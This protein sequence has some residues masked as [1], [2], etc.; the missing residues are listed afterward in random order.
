MTNSAALGLPYMAPSQ[1][2]KHVTH[3]EALRLLDLIVQ[4]SVVDRTRNTPPTGA[5][6]G[7]R[8][9]V[10]PAPTGIW[11]GQSAS[12]AVFESGN[13]SFLA[14]GTGWQAYIEDEAAMSVW[15]GSAWAALGP[16]YD[17]LPGIGINAT[18]DATNRL[19]LSAAATLFNHE[20][21]GHQLKINK[22]AAADTASLL[23][24]TNWSGRA[25]MGTAGTDGFAIKV[26]ADGSA[27]QDAMVFDAATGLATGAAV[28]TAATDTGAGKLMRADFGYG[29]GNLLGTVAQGAGTPTG[30]VLEAGTEYLRLA[31]GTQ[32]A[33]T[34]LG[35]ARIDGATLGATWTLPVPFAGDAFA[36]G[37]FD[38]VSASGLTPGLDALGPVT[39]SA[40]N[41]TSLDVTLRRI[42]G[43][44]DF[45]TGESCT[46]RVTAMGRW[47]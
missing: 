20:G 23:F 35:L 33:W 21:A 10:G 43:Q 40:G 11:A 14:P 39:C 44:A 6:E 7:Q 46:V 32:I 15:T 1:A 36:S 5:I 2:Q 3:N 29:P 41:G 12:I 17:N 42:A 26:S 27:W 22:A 13:W 24:Q 16:D 28:Q 30:A 45:G 25:E 19:S 4:L 8:H 34:T 37:S 47:V 18:S 38:P 31:C 9:I